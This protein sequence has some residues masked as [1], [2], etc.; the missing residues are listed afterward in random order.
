MNNM[1][2]AEMQEQKAYLMNKLGGNEHSE[3]GTIIRYE[4][5]NAQYHLITR[6]YEAAIYGKASNVKII[7]LLGGNDPKTCPFN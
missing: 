3:R 4:L 7:Y 5:E 1:Q 2:L 6:A